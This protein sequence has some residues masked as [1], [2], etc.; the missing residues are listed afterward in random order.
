MVKLLCLRFVGNVRVRIFLSL[1]FVSNKIR[2]EKEEEI[3]ER[4][5]EKGTILN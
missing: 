3:E 2:A 4:R 1:N 5:G